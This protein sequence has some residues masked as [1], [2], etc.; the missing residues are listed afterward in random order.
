MLRMVL[1]WLMVWLCAPLAAAQDVALRALQTG[2][3]SRGWEAVGR[4]D[5]GGGSFCTAT[6]IAPDQVLTAAHCLYDSRSGAE[7][8]LSGIRFLPG[9]RLGRAEA[10]RAIRR[11]VVHPDYRFA[12][13]DQMSRVA[14]DLALLELQHPLRLPGLAPLGVGA[15]PGMGGQVGVVSYARGRAEAPSLEDAC[16]VMARGPAVLVLT[17]SVDFG[18]SGAPV[19]RVE[20]GVPRIVSV[21]SA[22]A[23][24]AGREVALGARLG[25]DVAMLQTRLAS[26]QGL[27][28]QAVP[29]MH[30]FG[31]GTAWGGGGAKVIRP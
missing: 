2:D 19:F 31:Q 10:Y 28:G 11:A 6:L 16:R 4:L 14:H 7:L 5:L 3:D 21:V 29:P 13:S 24:A 15:A 20:G 25:D 30:R 12:D 22:R 1:V 26:G 8:D 27:V 18:A 23:E 9:L 17:C